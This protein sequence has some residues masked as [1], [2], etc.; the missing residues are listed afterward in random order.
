MEQGEWE[1]MYLVASICQSVCP[2]SVRLHSHG[3]KTLIFGMGVELDPGG[4]PIVV[5]VVGQRSVKV[6]CQKS[7][8]AS[9]LCNKLMPK[10]N[11]NLSPTTLT[12]N[13][14]LV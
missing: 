10:H 6:K 4:K 3:C 11:F 5:K 8:F 13:T 7:C 12:Y 2:Q 1:I 14:N 9:E